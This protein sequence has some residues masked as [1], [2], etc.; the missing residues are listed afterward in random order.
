MPLDAHY[1]QV[2]KAVLTECSMSR[3][4]LRLRTSAS[5]VK[6]I[7][8]ALEG[9]LGVS[10]FDRE[11]RGNFLPTSHA[12]RLDKEMTR[13][14]QEMDALQEVVSGMRETGRMLTL[15]VQPWL[16]NTAYFERLIQLLQQDTRF[17]TVLREIEP[18]S[19]RSVMES[20][21]CDVFVGLSTPGSK[22]LAIAHLPPLQMSLG[23]VAAG[24]VPDRLGALHESCPWGL[25]APDLRGV[26]RDWL[27]QIERE[28]G[29]IGR[30]ISTVQ[31]RDWLADPGRGTFR[32]V[33]SAA[34]ADPDAREDIHWHPFNVL[35]TVPVRA[36][37]LSQ[38]PYGCLENALQR[39]CNAWPTAHEHSL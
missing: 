1:L 10:L 32:A 17:R 15:G 2:F 39:A 30:A 6:R 5:N 4:A 22:R 23:M 13:F 34:P 19:E 37:F 7:V 11:S 16:R 18:G 25:H 35:P 3:A 9:E 8:Q 31:F 12:G 27:Q 14:M 29:G 20:G 33:V 21:A 38:H 24:P 36:T 28:G 26:S